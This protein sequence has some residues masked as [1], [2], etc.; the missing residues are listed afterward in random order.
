MR[1]WQRVEADRPIV[2]W[3]TYLDRKRAQRIATNRLPDGVEVRETDTGIL[4][5]VADNP[6]GVQEDQIRATAAAI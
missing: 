3:L 6:L 4:I 1:K 2:G 5:K